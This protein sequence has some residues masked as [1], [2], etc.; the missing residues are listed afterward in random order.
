MNVT[1]AKICNEESHHDQE[2]QDIILP[3][4]TDSVSR[5]AVDVSYYCELIRNLYIL[6]ALL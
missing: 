2:T 1:G 6:N 3:N 4:Q 5:I